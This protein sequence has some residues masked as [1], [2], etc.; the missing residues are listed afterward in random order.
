MF[1]R[2]PKFPPLLLF[3]IDA[4]IINAS[5]VVAYYIRFELLL[6]KLPA[7]VPHLSRFYGIL[8]LVTF[9]WLALFKLLG[10]YDKKDITS[11][12][13]EASSIFGATIVGT[14]LLLALLFLYRG[15]W[16]SRG[17]LLYALII[18]SLLMILS[19]Y[20]LSMI[21]RE[22][23]KRGI[24]V[25]RTLIVGAG[26]IGQGL[27]NK[28]FNE[29]E[30]GYEAVAYLDDDPEKLHKKF[31]G[32]PVIDSTVNIKNKIRELNIDEVIVATSRLP[33][34]KVLDIITEC[35]TEGV[36]FKLVPGIL[37]IIASRVS[38]DEIGGVPLLSIKEIGL[39]G[40]NANLKR[41]FDVAMSL[42]VIL[43]LSPLILLVIAAI[44]IDSRG[45]IV[46]SQKRVG[47]DGK[48]FNVYKFRSMVQEAESMF[49]SVVAQKKGD[50]IRFKAKDDPRITRVGRIIR[51][52]SLDEIPQLINVLKGDMS[53]VGPRPPVPVEVEHY[54]S[55]HRK[56]LR[57]RPGLTGLWQ[58]SGR[59]ELPFEDMVR[60][61]I[62]YIE[63]WSLW[64][65]FRIILRTIPTVLFGSGAY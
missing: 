8:I 25:R 49:E 45:P 23:Y 50:I 18:C 26:E 37:E 7:T 58:V 65:D 21:Q 14:L 5:F 46:F 29:K 55:W 48:T 42:F 10:L 22:L 60:L 38:S 47:K 9:L 28:I 64:M 39:K 16:F 61:D 24:G 4:I 52:F 20:V 1:K 17:V 19:R 30:I 11:A 43:I 15:F 3:I 54:S 13:D 36:E 51:K 41:S 63:N 53:L 62:Y 6:G 31:I 27:A 33:Q 34:Q 32:I 56:R 44:K 12:A 35:E 57:V 59:S 40:F 2:T